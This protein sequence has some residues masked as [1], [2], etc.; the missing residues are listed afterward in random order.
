[1]QQHFDFFF[2]MPSLSTVSSVQE[3]F[4]SRRAFAFRN[5]TVRGAAGG[6]L[7]DEGDEDDADS[8]VRTIVDDCA[9]AI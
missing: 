3:T 9:A 2:P 5:L 1:M 7:P 4:F 8:S 6:L